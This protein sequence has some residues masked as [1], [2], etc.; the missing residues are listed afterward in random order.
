MLGFKI[1]TISHQDVNLEYQINGGGEISKSWEKVTLSFARIFVK[2]S[3]PIRES[4]TKRM[5]TDYD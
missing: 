4:H 2:Q 5:L 3:R 1:D